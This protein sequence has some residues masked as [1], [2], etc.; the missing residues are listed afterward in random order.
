MKDNQTKTTI[1][2][3]SQ[4]AKEIKLDSDFLESGDLECDERGLLAVLIAFDAEVV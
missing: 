1:Y 2:R 3:I 4:V